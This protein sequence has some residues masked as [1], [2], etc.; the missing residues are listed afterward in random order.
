MR[1]GKAKVKE[2][3][4]IIKGLI[5]QVKELGTYVKINRDHRYKQGY[6]MVRF[7]YQKV[8]S[9]YSK[10]WNEAKEHWGQLKSCPYLTSA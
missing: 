3:W 5:D 2:Q 8:Y 7:S 10:K 4:Q 9:G 1:R 6:I